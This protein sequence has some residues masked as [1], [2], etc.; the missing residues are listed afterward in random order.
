MRTRA[1]RAPARID[2]TVNPVETA[3]SE[4]AKQLRAASGVL[5][6]NVE[7][8]SKERADKIKAYMQRAFLRFETELNEL[9]EHRVAPDA[10]FRFDMY[11]PEPSPVNGVGAQAPTFYRGADLK[12]VTLVNPPQVTL[13]NGPAMP[14]E[15]P[16]GRMIG[17]RE[18][19][20]AEVTHEAALVGDV[21]DEANNINFLED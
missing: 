3:V 1:K 12:R 11:L 20:F 19:V 16:V 10:D 18:P 21:A 2:L 13:M 14:T 4:V 15:R 8:L 6:Q 17:S 5:T 7:D 9:V